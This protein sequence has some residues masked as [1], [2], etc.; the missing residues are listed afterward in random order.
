MRRLFL[1]CAG[2]LALSPAV[3][4]DDSPPPTE[5]VVRLTVRPMAAP[6]PALKY[7]LLPELGEMNPGN[8]IQGYLK[9]FM[10]QHF[11]FNKNAVEERE[12]WQ[13]APLAELAGKGLRDY[14]RVPL[15]QADYAARLDTPDWQILLK[16]RSDGPYLLLPD[17][18]HLRGL[19][20]ALKVRFRAQVAERHFDEA[21]GTAKTMLALARHL[22][23][24]PTLIANL[25][26]VNVASVAI[27]PLEEMIAQPGCPNLYWA[28]T[29]LPDPLV[30]LRRGWQGERVM[31][32]GVMGLIDET[33]PM[34]EA[35]MD[36][37]IARVQEVIAVWLFKPE[38]RPPVRVFLE[39]WAKDEAG[40]RAARQRLV[41]A[42][43]VEERVQRFPALQVILV[44][45]RLA[46]E[47]WR[48]DEEKLATLPPWQAEAHRAVP[49]M[50]PEDQW[51][52]LLASQ[53]LAS[54]NVQRKQVRLRQRIALL[55]TV[56]ALRLHAAEHDGKLPAQLADVGVPLP[57]D[58][59]TGKPFLYKVEGSTAHVRGSPPPGELKNP[60]YNVRYEVTV[61]K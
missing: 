46:Y 19:A 44:D 42:G 15:R 35:Q 41:E 55:R 23:E 21:L 5:T 4:A 33:A 10:E 38:R 13:T 1:A 58:P 34:T 14:G 28:L 36:R 24:H 49:R 11:F 2:L 30:D 47:R 53:L 17:V 52:K 60:D 12:K 31:Y 48:D 37:A 45:K 32:Q 6:K 59:F 9:C 7:Q 40:V 20:S 61:E 8:P 26:G 54:L 39:A 50:D 56:E 27:G 22:G 51:E 3:Q 57:L 43:L 25:V 16:L 18:Q 29:A